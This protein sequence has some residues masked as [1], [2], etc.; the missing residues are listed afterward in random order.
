MIHTKPSL[1][2]MIIIQ[3]IL[4]ENGNY[5][6]FRGFLKY[7]LIGVNRSDYTVPRGLL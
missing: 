7:F 2:P 4:R 1:S 5:W 3:I 6:I